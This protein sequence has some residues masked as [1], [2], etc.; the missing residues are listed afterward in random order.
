MGFAIISRMGR[1]DILEN[2]LLCKKQFLISSSV[3]RANRY[4]PRSVRLRRSLGVA[5][6]CLV[7]NLFFLFDPPLIQFLTRL[8]KSNGTTLNGLTNATRR[9]AYA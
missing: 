7:I 4:H 5:N 6:Q 2:E 3:C 9:R 8:L 1:F